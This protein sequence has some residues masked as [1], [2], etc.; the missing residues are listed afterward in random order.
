M[1]DLLTKALESYEER[2]TLAEQMKPVANQVRIESKFAISLSRRANHAHAAGALQ[3]AEKQLQV[4]QKM[5]AKSPHLARLGF[6]HEALEEYVEA[7]MYASLLS[8]KKAIFP[9]KI[10]IEPDILLGG[11]ADATGEL[12][13]RAITIANSDTFDVIT[14]YRE[15]AEEVAEK[16][17]KVRMDGK[18]RKK[19]DD[20]ERNLRRLEEILYDIR[21]K[22]P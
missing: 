5:T 21:L 6:Y 11:I 7:K 22:K 1:H 8:D 18:I 20:V 12:V 17:S 14:G 10:Q 15:I 2:N 3:K 9:T 16:L 19:Y 13:R 4:L